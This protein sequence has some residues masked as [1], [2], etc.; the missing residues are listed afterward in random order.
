MN[1]AKELEIAKTIARMAASVCQNIQE[2]LVVKA[3]KTGRE[4]VTIADYASQ[5]IIGH[6]LAANFSDDAVLSEERSEEYMLLLSNEQRLQVQR[7][8]TDALGGYVFEDD[9]CVW[10][11][12]G[13]QKQE[14]RTWVIDPIDGTKG[15]L[16]Q[17]HYCIAIGLLIDGEPVLGTLASPG[18]FSD[19]HNPPQDI[20]ALTFASRGEG[21]YI[22][23]LGGGKPV[24]IRVSAI[25][26]PLRATMLTSFESAHTDMTFMDRVERA[27]GRKRGAP[28][29]RL[30]SQD[31]HAMVATGMGEV[32][33]RLVPD[34][35][36]REKMWDHAAGC[37]VVTEAGGRVTDVHG[38]PLD[39]T[40]GTRMTNNRGVLVTNGYLHDA[41]LAAVASSDI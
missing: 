25:N 35:N 16:G 3:E 14:Q 34:S 15:F 4:P 21:A 18:F 1:L 12:F 8:V 36:F 11:D 37:A 19:E 24:P 32:Y 31:K 38:Q 5:A 22:E 29:R 7:F 2:E 30:D 10:L 17:R 6:A 41:I 13:K 9:I 27:L 40:T 26:D 39:F 33:M 28:R 23:A 20:G